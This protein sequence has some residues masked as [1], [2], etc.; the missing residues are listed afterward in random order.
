MRTKNGKP[1][2]WTAS[3]TEEMS[4]IKI[5]KVFTWQISIFLRKVVV[6]G[7]SLIKCQI[8]AI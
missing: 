5:S 4:Q 1:K 3:S 8:P 7:H 2:Q 6:I